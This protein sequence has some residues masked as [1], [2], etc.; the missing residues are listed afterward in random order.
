MSPQKLLNLQKITSEDITNDNILYIQHGKSRSY[1]I[2]GKLIFGDYSSDL[3]EWDH[4]ILGAIASDGTVFNGNIYFKINPDDVEF[5]ATQA[6]CL[7]NLAEKFHEQ[8]VNLYIGVDKSKKF[9]RPTTSI[10]LCDSTFVSFLKNILKLNLGTD[11]NMPYW[12]FENKGFVNPWLS[13]LTDGDGDIC[14]FQDKYRIQWFW[15]LSNGNMKP[16]KI[17]K[18]VLIKF[19]SSFDASP[20]LDSGNKYSLRTSN[21]DFLVNLFTKILPYVI[22]ERKRE[23][24]IKT[25]DYFRQKGFDIKVSEKQR[26]TRNPIMDKVVEFLRERNLLAR[27]QNWEKLETYGKEL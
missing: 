1:K 9:G 24:I 25:L 18:E 5:S 7:I 17:V 10:A 27:L 14:Y 21:Y 22:L 6:Y 8:K 2:P 3:T 13:G 12:L 16:L 11:F 15:R 20:R 26:T 23:R 4:Y 19:Y